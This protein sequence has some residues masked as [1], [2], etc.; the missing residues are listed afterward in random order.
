M[1]CVK[2]LPSDPQPAEPGSPALT[3]APFR[4]VRYAPDRVSGLA[5]VTSPPYDV[6]G[7]QTVERLL[8]SDPYNVVRLIL[9]GAA[10]GTQAAA[11][12]LREW[13]ASGVLVRDPVP[14][15]YVYEQ[16][17]PAAADS[18]DGTMA[19]NGTVAG[20]GA[21]APSAPVIQRGLIG[22]LRLV[23]PSARRVLPH[24]DVMPG[25]VRGRRELMEATQAN[26]EP[27]FVL[28]DSRAEGPEAGAPGTPGTPEAPGSAV[29][30]GAAPAGARA[31]VRAATATQL[32]AEV[33]ATRE[34]LLD[35]TTDD[36]V[37]HRLWAVTDPAEHAMVA[38]DLAPRRALIADGH[39][40]YAAY[41]D[42]QARRHAAGSGPGPWD[43]G[44]AFLVD[45]AAYPP[46]IGAIHRVVP[47]LSP[48][49]AAGLAKSAF[50]V[51]AIGGGLGGALRALGG[52]GRGGPAFL[53]TGGAADGGLAGGGE[54]Y[55]LTEPD[56]GALAAAMPSGRSPHWRGL[57]PAVLSELLIGRVWRLR[58]SEPDV[59]VV[60]GDPAAAVRAAAEAGGTAVICNP[61]TAEDVHAVAAN[62]ERVPR[63][64]T[65]FG[66][67]PRTGLVIRTLEPGS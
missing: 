17:V 46:R 62:G 66:P 5:D 11:R 7:R 34:P 8:A 12:A 26:L 30:A 38:A 52:A 50:S 14:A 33:A 16:R 27:I 31:A 59:L 49:Q 47:R 65:S 57:A 9:P 19:G 2:T 20:T 23:P 60:H 48:A 28:Y 41:L 1:T 43:Y 67:K 45:Q 61:A 21:P 56:P 24:E 37:V 35:A 44:L 29:R 32:V 22:A 25:P 55:L 54:H 10:G 18:G 51:Q 58:D 53:L 39:H 4:G 6:I 64:S 13:L 36:G 63:K 15:L 40:R 3:L 42:M